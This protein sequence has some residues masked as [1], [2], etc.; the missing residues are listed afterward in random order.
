MINLKKHDLRLGTDILFNIPMF[1]LAHGNRVALLAPNGT[2][3]SVFMRQLVA[4]EIAHNMRLAYCPQQLPLQR[5]EK[6]LLQWLETADD[7]FNVHEYYRLCQFFGL[8]LDRP[9]LTFSGGQER[10]AALAY[11]L[12]QNAEIFL[13][14]EP[15]NH[16]DVSSI[17]WL[18]NY[19]KSKLQS[20]MIISHDLTF[21]ENIVDGYWAIH[22]N[23]LRYYEGDYAA[24][25]SKRETEENSLATEHTR[26]LLALK[27]EERYRERGV[28]ARRSRNQRRVE[29]LKS[30]REEIKSKP[31]STSLQFS[32]F[33]SSSMPASQMIIKLTEFVPTYFQEGRAVDLFALT[34]MITRKDR[35]AIVGENGKGKTTL[36]KRL[37]NIEEANVEHRFNIQVST[38]DQQRLLDPEST[39]IEIVA[40]GRTEIAIQTDDKEHFL[41][42]LSYLKRFGLQTDQAMTQYGKLS[43]GEKMKVCL[44][45]ALAKPVDVLVLDEPTNDLDIEAVE[46]LAELLTQFNGL[47]LLVTHDRYLIDQCATETWYLT[48][49]ELVIHPG[50]F[51]ARFL[52]DTAN[53]KNKQGSSSTKENRIQIK[54]IMK[55]IEKN[56]AKLSEIEIKLTDNGLYS[57]DSQGKLKSLQDS[58]SALCEHI[59]RL[60]R[61]WEV[62][63]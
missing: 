23:K 18:E 40:S 25:L 34:R 42:P 16:L 22:E 24:Y 13:F 35:I 28:T 60:Y 21:L 36:L 12:C 52:E 32:D 27:A 53:I 9:V 8:D 44:A 3:K 51:E 29:K 45:K 58:K 46:E 20:Y 49:K 59:D 31:R 57:K 30:L 17:V 5:R 55:E 6:S 10:K 14:D 54:K 37:L 4:N 1:Q 61:E 48:S 41:H 39:P 56:E 19:I 47:V 15:T 11:A 26:K 43:G 63:Q 33:T 7:D 38:L 50:G 62:L 2:G